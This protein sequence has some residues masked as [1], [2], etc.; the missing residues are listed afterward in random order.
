MLKDTQDMNIY[1]IPM[2]A[3][4]SDNDSQKSEHETLQLRYSKEKPTNLRV[5]ARED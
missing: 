5:Q 1:L 4:Q 2:T 3:E